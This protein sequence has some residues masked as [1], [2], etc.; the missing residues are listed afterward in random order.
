MTYDE[1][2]AVITAVRDGK[3]VEFALEY[4][5]DWCRVLSNHKF[6]F[7]TYRYRMKPEAQVGYINVF[8]CAPPIIECLWPSR[9]AADNFIY[10]R[11]RIACV[12]VVFTPGQFD[13]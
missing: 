13:K 4:K 6:D 1:M 11:E 5:A 7:G 3:E 9:K 8:A 12:R 2:I 10:S